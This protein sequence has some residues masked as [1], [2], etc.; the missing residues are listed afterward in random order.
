MEHFAEVLETGIGF[1][2][3]RDYVAACGYWTAHWAEA[4][5]GEAR[6]LQGL[7]QIA[8]GYAKAESGNVAGAQKLMGMGIDKLRCYAPQVHG[9]DIDVFVASVRRS[10]VELSQL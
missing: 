5:P 9:I 6:L 7:L 4:E 2:N 8:A 3:Q 1:F 10:M